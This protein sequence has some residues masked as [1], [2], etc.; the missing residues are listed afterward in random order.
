[1]AQDR[2]NVHDGYGVDVHQLRCPLAADLGVDP[3]PR[4]ATRADGDHDLCGTAS[5]SHHHVGDPTG[6][7][8]S[9]VDLLG[10][11]VSYT[12]VWGK[13]SNTTYDPLTGRVPTMAALQVRM[14]TPTTG[15]GRD[16]TEVG[17]QRHRDP[18]VFPTRQCE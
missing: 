6:T 5:R 3:G 16:A 4:D 12:D 9:T 17:W 18:H 10:R 15:R 7:I 8:T 11:S 2:R 1:M 13:T 14:N